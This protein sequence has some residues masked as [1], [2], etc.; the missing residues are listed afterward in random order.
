MHISKDEFCSR[1]SSLQIDWEEGAPECPL[2]R[3]GIGFHL[4][5]LQKGGIPEIIWWRLLRTFLWIHFYISVH[6]K[7]SIVKLTKI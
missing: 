3:E 7:A 4:R 5:E 2:E 1:F 6:L